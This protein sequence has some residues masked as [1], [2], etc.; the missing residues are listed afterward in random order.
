M[1]RN[2]RSTLAVRRLYT[3]IPF[4]QVAERKTSSREKIFG[5]KAD[6]L[7]II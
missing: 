7:E 3:I 5:G 6:R 1:G 2:D 4:D